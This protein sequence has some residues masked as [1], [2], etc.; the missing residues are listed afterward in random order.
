MQPVRPEASSYGIREDGGEVEEKITIS[1]VIPTAITIGAVLITA[2]YHREIGE[3]LG[4]YTK[5]VIENDPN[6]LFTTFNIDSLNA[7]APTTP[8][9]GVILPRELPKLPALVCSKVQEVAKDL[10]SS[11]EASSE[12]VCSKVKD[13]CTD[14]PKEGVIEHISNQLSS[15]EEVVKKSAA[16]SPQGY[17]MTVSLKKLPPLEGTTKFFCMIN[18]NDDGSIVESL[19]THLRNLMN[20]AAMQSSNIIYGHIPAEHLQK[21]SENPMNRI[22]HFGT[23][24]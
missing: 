22:L 19:K 20:F 9:K 11:V 7:Y 10:C 4:I 3:F 8:Q 1:D 14:L 24:S 18:P 5:K 13:V 15:I 21:N 12:D 16:F 2:I 23:T 17:Q 6:S